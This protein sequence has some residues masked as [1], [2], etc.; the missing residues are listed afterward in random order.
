MSSYDNRLGRTSNSDSVK[1][2]NVLLTN[3]YKYR[4]NK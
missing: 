3:K 4:L 2:W 1:N